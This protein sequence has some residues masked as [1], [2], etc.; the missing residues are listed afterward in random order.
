[1]SL[2]NTQR[3][4]YDAIVDVEELISKIGKED[5][6]TPK[7]DSVSACF[8]FFTSMAVFMFYFY[9]IFYTLAPIEMFNT[10]DSTISTSHRMLS[11]SKEDQSCTL[12]NTATSVLVG[13]VAGSAVVGAT[14]LAIG[15][16]PLGPI[17]GGL[18]AANMG[19]GVAAGKGMDLGIYKMM[20]ICN[21][22]TTVS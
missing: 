2:L 13:V 16:T 22:F 14:F 10:P 12:S 11:V 5:V 4:G 1:M 15:L 18:F 17:A 19:A 20:Y 3:E 8:I 9:C 6:E 21:D 7:K